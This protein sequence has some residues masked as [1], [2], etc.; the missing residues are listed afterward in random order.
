MF[1]QAAADKFMNQLFNN[2]LVHLDKIRSDCQAASTPL[3]HQYAVTND[4][5]IR[6]VYL[7]L[8]ARIGTV[9]SMCIAMIGDKGC[10]VMVRSSVQK[11]FPELQPFKP[12]PNPTPDQ[13]VLVDDDV[14][15]DQPVSSDSS[16]T[17][18][19][20]PNDPAKTA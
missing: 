11:M 6:A 10:S 9:K 7:G 2:A 19:V 15:G 8:S 3:A 16:V 12:L 1:D 13:V 18:V 14:K 20:P 5:A 4:P 17:G